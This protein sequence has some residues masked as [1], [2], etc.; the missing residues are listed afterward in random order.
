MK[1]DIPFNAAQRFQRLFHLNAN[2]MLIITYHCIVDIKGQEK[3]QQKPERVLFIYVDIIFINRFG[4]WS[5]N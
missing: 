3:Y 4:G 1:I 5:R 2:Y